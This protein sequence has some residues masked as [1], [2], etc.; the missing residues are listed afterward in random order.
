MTEFLQHQSSIAYYDKNRRGCM[1]GF[2][3]LLHFHRHANLRKLLSYGRHEE[4]GEL[5]GQIKVP[6]SR[7][8][9][10]QRSSDKEVNYQMEDEA[11][12]KSSGK[13]PM[14]SSLYRRMAKKRERKMRGSPPPSSSRLLRT[15]SIHHLEC[16]DYVAH[17]ETTSE[18]ELMNSEENDLSLVSRDHSRMVAEAK[19]QGRSVA[20]QSEYDA[21]KE[22]STS[23]VFRD[24]RSVSG[25]QLQTRQ[26][27]TEETE[28]I[29]SASFPGAGLTGSAVGTSK[30]EHKDKVSS[31]VQDFKSQSAKIMSKRKTNVEEPSPQAL[32]SE[33]RDAA[34]VNSSQLDHGKEKKDPRLRISMD[35]IL[36]KV[37]SGHNLPEYIEKERLKLE[38]SG[39]VYGG[40]KSEH[41]S[42]RRS[43]SLVESLDRYS[44]LLDSVSDRGPKRVPE[45]LK[46]L[47]E[48]DDSRRVLRSR[49]LSESAYRSSH[50]IKS[51]SVREPRRGIE[52]VVSVRENQ[53]LPERK[54]MKILEILQ[55]PSSK[56]IQSCEPHETASGL[57]ASEDVDTYVSDVPK[58]VDSLVSTEEG[59]STVAVEPDVSETE[60]NEQDQDEA[61]TIPGNSLAEDNYSTSLHEKNEVEVTEPSPSSLL[62][63]CLEEDVVDPEKYEQIEGAELPPSWMQFEQHDSGF[64]PEYHLGDRYATKEDVEVI[65]QQWPDLDETRSLHIP[66]DERDENEFNYVCDILRKSG[67]TTV[68]AE[69]FLWHSPLEQLMFKDAEGSAHDH[70]HEAGEDGAASNATPLD[71]QLMLDVTNEVLL[72]IYESSVARGTTKFSGSDPRIRPVPTGEHVLEEVWARISW[73]LDYSENYS[74][75]PL[76]N[77]VA[78][79]FARGDGW[80]DLHWDMES[81]GLEVEDLIL[82]E[83]IDELL[84]L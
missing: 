39:L 76:D 8:K 42:M 31:L 50:L 68:G 82:D 24:R 55:Y 67:L 14:L 81:V 66:V 43:R 5:G 21:D 26:A 41:R 1:W 52:R 46:S 30:D 29:K 12:K 51:S 33:T 9:I 49:S 72:G 36:H 69:E 60:I 35:G 59:T 64:S 47:K 74:S 7:P 23:R 19:E 53:C 22:Y 75:N 15:F 13:V 6:T 61:C 77:V 56:D 16:N 45:R 3:H 11:S 28:L 20:L 80:M 32:E 48:E 54:S 57:L 17:N 65:K 71:R 70:D 79:D 84:L 25:N 62:G 44:P 73:Y 18:S 40:A 2:F 63:T 4:D 38:A 27:S 58:F 37:P 34:T 83:L 10:L 78:R